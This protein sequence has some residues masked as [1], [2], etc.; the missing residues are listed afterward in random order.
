MV[1]PGAAFLGLTIGCARC[2]DHKY[3]PVSTAD[4]YSM[5]SFVRSI[6]GYGLQHTG[7]G[8]RGTGKIQRVLAS[9]AGLARWESEKQARVKEAEERLAD[10]TDPGTRKRLE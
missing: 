4:Y 2:H 8:G 7:R 5:L 1:T 3:D 9:P 10:A 6:D